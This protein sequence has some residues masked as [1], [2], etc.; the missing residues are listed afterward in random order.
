MGH[1]RNYREKKFLTNK[2]KK[3]KILKSKE[4]SKHSC[5]SY[6]YDERDFSRNKKTLK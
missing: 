4:C 6:I 2:N 3:Q 1:W 5:K